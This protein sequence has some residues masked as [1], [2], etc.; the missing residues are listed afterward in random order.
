MKK[1]NLNK[2]N[3]KRAKILLKGIIPSLVALVV[4]KVKKRIILTSTRNE[5]YNFNSRYL[6]E[7]LIEHYP[8]WEIKYVI[9][10]PHKRAEL[11]ARF[12]EEHG[13]FIETETL[14]GMWY[15]L[16][17]KTWCT[18]ALETPVGGVFQ[19][20]G[21]IVLHL[22]HGAYFR[23]ALF[24]ENTLPWYKRLYYHVIKNNFS[25]HLITSDDI[26]KVAPKMFGCKPEQIVILGEPM[27]DRI[28]D[29][30]EKLFKNIFGEK[31]LEAKNI[32]YAPTWRQDG[33]LRLFP[34]DDMDWDAFVAF[35]EANNI[36]IFLRLHPSYEEDLT[37]YTDKTDHIKIMDSKA[38]EDVNEVIALFDMVITDYSS[39][40]AGYL[41]L[42]KPLL[43]LSYDLE[44]Y[45]AKTGFVVPYDKAT[46]GPKPR[47][48]AS[49]K[50]EIVRLLESRDY[51]LQE[52]KEASI[53]FNGNNR[54]NNS[55]KV[56][57][58]LIEK[59]EGS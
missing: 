4:P 29:P 10:N 42:H 32:L 46:A 48:M 6:F 33:S 28:F 8:D 1:D 26:A 22:G 16:R 39:V 59:L 53:L 49:F 15:A 18:S 5:Y 54:D 56:A 51:Y 47:T 13:Y 17:A 20:L 11:N 19:K 41:L 34:F 37:F 24:I 36:N 43:F 21:R 7:Y 45:A 44:E 14:G 57:E 23:S 9:N 12:G 30:N 38:V 50:E 58:F 52:R 35:L 3:N 27:N 40:Y 31:I 55:E 2:Y 25:H